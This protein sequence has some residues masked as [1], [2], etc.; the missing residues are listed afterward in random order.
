MA[1]LNSNVFKDFPV[2]D[3]ARVATA[4]L[5]SATDTTVLSVASGGGVLTGL[6]FYYVGGSNVT[7]NS[8]KVTVDGA[9]ERTLTFGHLLTSGAVID[10]ISIPMII[11]FDASITVK[12]NTTLSGGATMDTTT[13][14]LVK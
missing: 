8:I 10:T 2:G 12:V 3:K 11:P 5:T 1:T 4:S 14:Y 9:S 6:T 13:Q 7:L